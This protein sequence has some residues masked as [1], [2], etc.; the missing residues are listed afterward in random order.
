MCARP[1][2]LSRSSATHRL[3]SAAVERFHPVGTSGSVRLELELDDM[4]PYSLEGVRRLDRHPTVG[5]P[6]IRPRRIA[7]STDESAL[8]AGYHSVIN[9]YSDWCGVWQ[10]RTTD[11]N[12]ERFCRKKNTSSASRKYFHWNEWD[13][14][15]AIKLLFSLCLLIRYNYVHTFP[16]TPMN[17]PVI[18]RQSLYRH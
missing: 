3:R 6:G 13:D 16:I 14:Q 7:R 2:P 8:C 17:L 1:Q 11:V 5:R 15:T 10:R 9:W 18:I 12:D 4:K